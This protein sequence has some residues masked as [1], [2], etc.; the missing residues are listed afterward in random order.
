LSN[1]DTDA[2]RKLGT[3]LGVVA[4]AYDSFANVTAGAHSAPATLRGVT[5]EYRVVGQLVV[6]QGR[7]VEQSDLDRRARFIVISSQMA[8]TLFPSAPE[9]A[10]GQ[11][12]RIQ[13]QVYTVIG[14]LDGDS[15]VGLAG[16][17]DMTAYLPLTTAQSRLAGA[18]S[19]E[20]SQIVVTARDPADAGAAQQQVRSIL[21]ASHRLPAGQRDDF[22]LVDQRELQQALQRSTGV[23][24]L[25]LASIAGISLFVGGI[26][27]MNIMLVS[28]TE[29]TR[30][31]GLRKALGATPWNILGQFLTESIILTMLGGAIGAGLGYGIAHGIALLALAGEE[32]LLRPVITPQV[33]LL[34]LSVSI[35]IGL[36]FGLW[37]AYRAARMNPIDALRYE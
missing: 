27:I 36:F 10:V 29:R 26:G 20:L 22:L 14:V 33:V 31:I 32:L 6:A 35:S 21:R 7:F 24:T 15:S 23:L 18:G 2:L 3:Y 17:G 30:E 16:A 4:P 19:R 37:P 1:E 8:R 25:L 12:V 9:R 5:P 11:T 34:A 28:V 13:R